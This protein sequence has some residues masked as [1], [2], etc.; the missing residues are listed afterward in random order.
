MAVPALFTRTSSR[1]KV[2]TAPRN[3]DAGNG[4]EHITPETASIFGATCNPPE[5][6]WLKVFFADSEKSQAAGRES[7][8]RY[9]Q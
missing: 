4:Q 8:K 3:H 9:G 6:L 5:N 2:G 7:L 1:P